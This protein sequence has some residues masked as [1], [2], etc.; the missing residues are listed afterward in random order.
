M[1]R[2]DRGEGGPTGAETKDKV[3]TG[4][5][6]GEEQKSLPQGWMVTWQM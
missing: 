4:A 1:L 2:R 3:A 6:E 5:E